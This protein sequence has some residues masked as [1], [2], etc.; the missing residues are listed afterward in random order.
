MMTIEEAKKYL[1]R[2]KNKLREAN[3]YKIKIIHLRKLANGNGSMTMSETPGCQVSVKK[4]L[5]DIMNE[6]LD[7]E[8][9]YN[10]MLLEAEKICLEIERDIYKVGYNNPLYGNILSYYY[11]HG[12]KL[13]DISVETRYCYRQTKRLFNDALK[14][15]CKLKE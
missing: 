2:Y 7:I 15:F 11:I 1:S 13:I 4:Q 10:K 8:Q 5:K 6:L 12:L 9:E 14:M 3:R